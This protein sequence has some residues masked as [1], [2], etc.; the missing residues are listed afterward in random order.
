MSSNR[1]ARVATKWPHQQPVAIVDFRSIEGSPN[2][3]VA[4]LIAEEGEVWSKVVSI[5]QAPKEVRAEASRLELT[6]TISSE[7]RLL[8]LQKHGADYLQKLEKA[9]AAV[10]N[11]M[12]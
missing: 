12:P 3:C 4:V 1:R 8:F 5:S 11:E 9:R 2:S 6:L 10:R 7:D